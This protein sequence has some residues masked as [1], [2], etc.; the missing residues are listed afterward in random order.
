V[1]QK[2]KPVSDGLVNVGGT[3]GMAH[4]RS[5]A[6]KGRKR[7]AALNV[8]LLVVHHYL[9]RIARTCAIALPVGFVAERIR[10]AIQVPADDVGAIGRR[11]VDHPD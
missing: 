10:P 9:N 8:P 11:T 7:D 3:F 1:Q 2:F 4:R 6:R 5:A